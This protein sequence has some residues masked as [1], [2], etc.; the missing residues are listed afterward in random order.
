MKW[1][2]MIWN[3]M[4]YLLLFLAN[5]CSL[6]V[7]L[8]FIFVYVYVSNLVIFC[9]TNFWYNMDTLF[10]LCHQS[11]FVFC[12]VTSGNVFFYVQTLSYGATLLR[13]YDAIVLRRARNKEAMR[14][15][16][17]FYDYMFYW[18]IL[19]LVLLTL[20]N[21]LVGVTG[22]VTKEYKTENDVLPYYLK[23]KP[24][25]KKLFRSVFWN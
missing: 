13:C 11:Y 12:Q 16:L 3:G 10:I 6:I 17:Y 4:I 7:S 18:L 23:T 24:G 5:Y 25:I 22:S 15:V 8:G 2:E 1:N 20:T 9:Q 19:C 14:F 21:A